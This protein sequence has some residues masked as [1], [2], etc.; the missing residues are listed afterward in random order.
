VAE[1]A[2]CFYSLHPLYEAQVSLEALCRL[3]MREVEEGSHRAVGLPVR[4]ANAILR[5]S[6]PA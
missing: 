6:P 5:G 1:V 2:A 4:E 3:L